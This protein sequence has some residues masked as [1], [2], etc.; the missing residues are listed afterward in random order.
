METSFYIIKPHGL[1]FREEVRAMIEGVGLTITESKELVVHSWALEIIYSDLPE[2]YR[3]AVFLQFKGK[4]V[5]VGLVMGENAIDKLLQ[6]TGTE[7]DPVDCALSSIRFK[8]GGHKP[9]IINGVRCYKNIIH[10]SQ[11]KTEAENGIKVFRML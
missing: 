6:I 2:K 1:A 3:D 11:N 8:F 10:R 7:L 5:E 9:L 4:S